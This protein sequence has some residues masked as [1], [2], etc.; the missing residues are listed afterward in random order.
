MEQTKDYHSKT[1][2]KYQ[3]SIQDA[4]NVISS[5]EKNIFAVVT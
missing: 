3:V 1:P 2:M 5:R 4:K